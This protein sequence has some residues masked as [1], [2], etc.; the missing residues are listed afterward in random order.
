MK[1]YTLK[2]LPDRS[3]HP[4]KYQIRSLQF[5]PRLFE[6]VTRLSLNAGETMRVALVRARKGGFVLEPCPSGYNEVHVF[7]GTV[8]PSPRWLIRLVRKRGRIRFTLRPVGNG[9]RTERT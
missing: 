4:G 8:V 9:G 5:C 6:G 2:R 7:G 3:Y 1:T